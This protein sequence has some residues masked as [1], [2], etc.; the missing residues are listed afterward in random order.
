MTAKSITGFSKN[1]FTLYHT[2]HQ[3]TT[4]TTI[5]NQYDIHPEVPASELTSFPV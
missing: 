5:R 4:T 3:L 1:N 2:K